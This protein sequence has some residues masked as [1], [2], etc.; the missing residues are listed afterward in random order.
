[1]LVPEQRA[2]R[3]GVIALLTDF[4]LADPYVGQMKGALLRHAPHARIL[5]LHHDVPV[6][7]VLQAA[8]FLESSRPY[9]PD[10]ALLLAV[11][12]PG[13]GSSRKLL[14][15]E[16][17][18]HVFLGPDNGIFTLLLDA[19]ERDHEP[20]RAVSLRI[21]PTDNSATFHGRDILA[22]LAGRL[23]L[24]VALEE[25]G[26][27]MPVDLIQRLD[28]PRPRLDQEELHARV[29]HV[30]RFGD[31]L[32][33]T[34]SQDWAPVLASWPE[35]WLN[36]PVQAALSLINAYHQLAPE[37]LGILAGSQ[38]FLELALNQA[39]AARRLGLAPGAPVLLSPQPRR[40]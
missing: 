19:I 18:G 23:L 24:G 21:D 29:L 26:Q 14:G 40:T 28:L 25:L 16:A 3:S 11:V 34:P 38:G 8:F 36:A 30:D 31:C 2:S 37:Q 32:L 13:V 20:A 5:D 27:L 12:D 1:M 22:P 6:C 10:G 39:S 35:I 17:F 7:D 9:L 15:L 33:N 4:G